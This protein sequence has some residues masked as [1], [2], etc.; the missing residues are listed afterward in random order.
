[1]VDLTKYPNP[2]RIFSQTRDEWFSEIITKFKIP[3]H[4][5]T[6]VRDTQLGQLMFAIETMRMNRLRSGE[7]PGP[8][9][10]EGENA[11]MFIPILKL[12]QDFRNLIDNEE[13]KINSKTL[14]PKLMSEEVLSPLLSIKKQGQEWFTPLTQKRLDELL[15]LCTETLNQGLITPLMKSLKAKTEDEFKTI[16]KEKDEIFSNSLFELYIPE[17]VNQIKAN[18]FKNKEENPETRIFDLNGEEKEFTFNELHGKLNVLYG[19][20]FELNRF[21]SNQKKYTFTFEMI[22]PL[23]SLEMLIMFP[24]PD[25][26]KLPILKKHMELLSSSGKISKQFLDLLL[27]SYQSYSRIETSTSKM[28]R[29]VFQSLEKSMKE[30]SRQFWNIPS[31]KKEM[32]IFETYIAVLW[33]HLRALQSQA[34][35]KEQY[36]Q[37]NQN[38]Q[39][40]AITIRLEHIF[41]IAGKNYTQ[42]EKYNSA[43]HFWST[44][45]SIANKQARTNEASLGL[46]H[47]LSNIIQKTSILKTKKQ[48]K[49][50]QANHADQYSIIQRVLSYGLEARSP[51]IVDEL[52]TYLKTLEKLLSK[53]DVNEMHETFNVKEELKVIKDIRNHIKVN[54]ML[55]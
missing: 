16:L 30:K 5:F 4:I 21:L 48:Q 25:T 12:V 47:E 37:T 8:G 44:Y 10:L 52:E 55:S 46:F 3:M 2:L 11:T 20:I 51:I 19:F 49:L 32:N 43:L 39:N 36:A 40:Y 6:A 33:T 34:Q 31:N 15:I 9:I 17:I 23:L 1:M 28:V 42:S 26:T 41:W 13:N 45:A 24:Q 50:Y 7:E 53:I 22:E 29:K 18:T 27:I 14:L 35:Y 38:S 54:I